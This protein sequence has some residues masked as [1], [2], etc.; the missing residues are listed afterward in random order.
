MKPSAGILWRLPVA[1]FLGFLAV[2]LAAPLTASGTELEDRW[3]REL[4]SRHPQMMDAASS[5]A[6]PKLGH[7]VTRF[8]YAHPS[9]RPFRADYLEAVRGSALSLRSWYAQQLGGDV[10]ATLA[11]SVVVS[12]ALDQPA[13]YYRTHDSGGSP[14]MRWWDNVLQE[15]QAKT[16]A[17]FFDR[18]SAW[19]F[20]VD[21]PVGCGQLGGAGTSSIT[22]MPDNDL[23]GLLGD[24]FLDCEGVPQ[25]GLTFTPAR[26]IGGQGH[27]L[28]H[29]Y[30]LPH[31]PGCDK[32]LPE[33]DAGAL[34]WAGFYGGY[35]DATYLRADDKRVVRQSPFVRPLTPGWL[36]SDGFD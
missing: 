31:P 13:N 14:F 30:G 8:I 15:L 18:D 22:L 17:R 32:G 7:A 10:S 9:D 27:E 21:A 25:P 26:W 6:P 23:R 1:R 19:V 24:V 33:C 3:L 35:P 4:V 12:V 36:F 16:G 20:L 29:A 28:G 2:A 11:E 34:M 5:R